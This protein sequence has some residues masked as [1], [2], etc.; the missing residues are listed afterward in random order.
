MRFVFI[1]CIFMINFLFANDIDTIRSWIANKNYIRLCTNNVFDLA[2][3]NKDEGLLSAYAEACL[4]TDFINKLSAVVVL[5]RQTKEGREN[6]V[7]YSTI[8]YKKKLLHL[9]MVDGIDISS[10]K[11]PKTDYVLSYIYDAYVDKKYKFENGVY[12]FEFG[13]NIYTINIVNENGYDKLILKSYI[14]D[15]LL[16]TK[17][18]W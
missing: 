17:S 14:G 5:L 6:A 13:A 9:S 2:N 16:S 18:Y 1:V 10:I 8:L 7:Y 4:Q 15:K 11:L 12:Y 3:K